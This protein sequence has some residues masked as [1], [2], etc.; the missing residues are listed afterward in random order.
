MAHWNIEVLKLV[1][2]ATT[3][4]TETEYFFPS[5]MGYIESNEGTTWWYAVTIG[6]HVNTFIGSNVTHSWWKTFR[7][8]CRCCVNE[9]LRSVHTVTATTTESTENPIFSGVVAATV[10]TSPRVAMTPIFSVVVAV[11]IGYRTLSWLPAKSTLFLPLPS[12]C[13]RSLNAVCEIMLKL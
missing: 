2:T 9:P 5:R 4:A 3:K 10:W 13:E 8:R 1:H 6:I 12:Q 11:T 7:C